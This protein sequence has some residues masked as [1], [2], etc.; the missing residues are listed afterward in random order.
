[1][2]NKSRLILVSILLA[3]GATLTLTGIF[4]GDPM[5]LFQKAVFVCLECMGLG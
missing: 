4:L 2:Q 5:T 1:M 3:A